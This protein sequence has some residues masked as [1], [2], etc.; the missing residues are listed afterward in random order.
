MKAR[1]LLFSVILLGNLAVANTT[2]LAE[3]TTATVTAQTT[4]SSEIGIENDTESTL[5]SATVS[6]NTVSTEES[7][8]GTTEQPQTEESALAEA[9]EKSRECGRNHEPID[10]WTN[11]DT[12]PSSRFV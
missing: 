5:Q 4:G 11:I 6:E 1:N 12:Y 2:V 10:R 8:T 3:E 9:S 7:T